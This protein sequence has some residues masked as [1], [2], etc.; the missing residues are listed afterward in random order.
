M[1][2]PQSPSRILIIRLSAI[3]D[4]VMASPLIKTLRRS[5]P[6]ARLSWLAEPAAAGLLRDNPDL[7]E[8]IV[9]PRAEWRALW[10]ARRYHAWWSAVRD[11]VRVL[12][13]RR[14][15]LVLDVQGLLKSAAWARL[16]GAP[17]RIGLGSREG[18]A[19]L[20]TQVIA[21]PRSDA[22]IGSEYLHL[23]RELGLDS[24]DFAMDIALGADDEAFARARAAETGP[25]AVLCPFTTRPQ[26]HWFE[27]R[28][29]ELAEQLRARFGLTP[30]LLGGPDAREAAARMQQ[31]CPALR[32]QVGGT[33][34]TQSAALIKHARCLIGVDTGLTHMG[35]AFNVPT[36]ALFGS[37]RPY[38]DTTR[39]NARVLYHRLE[40]SPC[41]R[42][43]TCG[44][45]YTCMRLIEVNEVADTLAVLMHG[46][47]RA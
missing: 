18:G 25:Y 1:T 19:L 28:W 12:R 23:A 30:V 10:N 6:N 41:R 44:G 47:T 42:H 20:M 2:S 4:I 35:I 43:P 32:S 17:V 24:G 46:E 45:A 5:Y 37:T 27:E 38:L 29:P 31:A 15:D 36:V 26:K 11:F 9:W 33:T 21:R 39:A 13:R 22:R 7:D 34:L 14:F 3:G 8:V 40:C 16:S